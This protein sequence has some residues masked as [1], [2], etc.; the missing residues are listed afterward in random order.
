VPQDFDGRGS[1]YR[2]N[3]F[4][5]HL[6]EL[7][8][9]LP[10]DNDA[11]RH[12]R[13][14]SLRY[15]LIFAHWMTTQRVYANLATQFGLSERTV[16]DWVWKYARAIAA[17]HEFKILWE[18]FGPHGTRFIISVDGVHFPIKEPR[19][20]P[21]SKWFSHKSHGPALAYEIAL[22]LYV[23]QIAWFNGP[24]RAATADI[25]IFRDG[26]EARIPDGKLAVGDSGYSS[27]EKV[28]IIQ[29]NDS[30]EVRQFKERARARQENINE[31]LKR[32]DI[33]D[34]RFRYDAKKHRVVFTA[35]LVLVQ[36]DIE[37]GRP[38]L[39]VL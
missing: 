26:L 19:K 24:Y 5:S 29:E 25:T 39:S 6:E 16:Q 14:L 37:N 4:Q 20:L 22:S 15:L 12:P 1:D 23:D 21:S 8:T 38:L 18:N 10:E 3:R 13:N 33:L 17:L 11:Y 36:Y 7:R 9:L 31:R 27:S 35:G 34:N 28:S 2:G 30:E 32:F